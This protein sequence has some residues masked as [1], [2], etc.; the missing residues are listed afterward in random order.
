MKKLV[1]I[2][3]C[4][5]LAAAL[6]ACGSGTASGRKEGT[7][8]TV[9]DVLEQ[10]TSG[11]GE[12]NPSTAGSQKQPENGEAAEKPGTDAEVDLTE[13]SATMIYAEVLNMMQHPD[14]YIG[15]IVRMNGQFAVYHDESTD[16]YY[17]ACIIKDATQCCAQ[18]IEFE[19]AGDH[20]YPEDYPEL[21]SEIT[22]TGVFDIYTEPS[23]TYCTLREAALE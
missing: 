6:T 21:G 20:V 1:S 7:S 17:F 19:L 4:I 9:E 12:D 10:R 14:K 22:V 5:A 2:L 3:L 15:K 23:G 11:Q 8:P 16:K 18:G 13:M